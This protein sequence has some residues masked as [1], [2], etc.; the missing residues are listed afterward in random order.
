MLKDQ[1]RLR[2]LLKKNKGIPHR[3]RG[4]IERSQKLLQRRLANLPE[5]EIDPALPISKKAG[6]IADTIARCP[7]TVVVGETGSGKS[8]QLPKI[9]LSMGRGIKGFIGHTQ[10]RRLAARSVAARIA[11]ELQSDLGE[12]VGYKVRFGDRVGPDSL[13][14]VMTDGM[15][16]AELDKDRLLGHYDT[17]IVDEAHERSLNIDFLLGYLKRLLVRRRDLK[18]VITSATIDPKRFSSYYNDAPIIE[19]SGRSY[20]V[21]IR[22]QGQDD[23]SED[24]PDVERTL[25]ARAAGAIKRLSLESP[26][27]TLVFL[28]GEKEIRNTTALVNRLQLK[29]TEVLPLYARLTMAE[30]RAVFKPHAGC[31]VVLA[32]N[33]A[34]TSLT[35]PGIRYVVDTGLARISRYRPGRQ[36]QALPVERISQSSADQRKGRCG[37]V[38]QGV[39]IRLY[40]EEDYRDRPMFTEP[41]IL[42]TSLAAV[43]LKMKQLRLGDI[44]SFPFMD[45]PS[46]RLIN[47]GYK[48]LEE[49]EAIDANRRFTAVGRKLARIPIDPRL[50]RVLLAAD[51]LACVSEALI[52]C[53]ALSV[54]DPRSYPGDHAER[55]KA[56]HAEYEDPNSSFL[57]YL[58]LWRRYHHDTGGLSRKAEYKYCRDNFLS[59]T[60]MREWQDVHSQLRGLSKNL[61]LSINHRPADS[62][63]LHRSLLCGFLGNIGRKDE[64][65]EYLGTRAKRFLLHPASSRGKKA[66]KWIMCAE[67]IDTNRLYAHLTANIRP[68]WIEQAA[69]HLVKRTYS[70]PHWDQDRGEVTANEQVSLFGLV[71]IP[72]RKVSYARLEPACCREIFIRQALVPGRL[73]TNADLRFQKHN[74]NLIAELEQ[75]EHRSRRQDVVAGDQELFDY[76]DQH[77]PPDVSTASQ[78]AGWYEQAKRVDPDILCLRREQLLRR[79]VDHINKERFPDHLTYKGNRLRCRYH[80]E[81]GH[82]NDGVT[83]SV[84]LA[85]LKQMQPE[86]LTWLVPGLLLEKIICLIK[87]LPKSKRKNFAP[88]PDY[89]ERC[90]HLVDQ[91][92]DSLTAA[93]SKALKTLTGVSVAEEDWRQSSLPP[94]LKVNFE[95]LDASGRPVA[96]GRDLAALNGELAHAPA[97]DAGAKVE[98]ALERNGIT[99]WEFGDLPRSM[100]LRAEGAILTGYPALV[101]AGESVAIK[102]LD[103]REQAR[104]FHHQGVN[105]LLLLQLPQH[106]RQLRKRTPLLNRMCLKFAAIAPCDVLHEDLV[107]AAL[108]EVFSK[109]GHTQSDVRGQAVFNKVMAAAKSSLISVFNEIVATVDGILSLYNSCKIE[110]GGVNPETAVDIEHQLNALIYKGFVQ[111][112]GLLRLKHLPRYLQA[113]VIRIERARRSPAKD[114]DAMALIAPHWSRLQHMLSH[115]DENGERFWEYRWLLE[116]Y[117]VSLFAQELKTAAPVSDKRLHRKWLELNRTQD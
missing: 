105:R 110:L 113:V 114:A 95:V 39:C 15:L 112:T 38:A 2:S 33:V 42:R 52:I 93:L 55:A 21:E 59:I 35:V 80:F 12:L 64:R 60:R 66:G 45:A 94:H 73:E 31:R 53:S 49:L 9:C 63:A 91:N 100:P 62:D 101:D 24:N 67:L 29:Q 14:K 108:D 51:E 4:D 87:G 88:A 77:I 90:L 57:A 85:L 86:P 89:A 111:R 103:D 116:E 36:I 5:V 19:V 43:I 26:G 72:R 70:E 99:S 84:P 17:I 92:A 18:V 8:T 97:L 22:Y 74:L 37:R 81:P 25:E 75:L 115:P 28:P 50:G 11:E 7:V 54:Q 32:T 16:L 48:L 56:R 76:F 68:E 65:N 98:S 82:P 78:F 6:E 61:G 13:I 69:P 1:I 58:A 83:V 102:V 96:Y 71:V 107:A 34:E 30:Q 23:Q 79:S 117:R 106:A 46:T 44:E 47:D 41:E 27:D 40:D 109:S 20:P 3:L 104:Q 10:P